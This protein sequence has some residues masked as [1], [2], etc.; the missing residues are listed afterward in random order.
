MLFKRFWCLE[1]QKSSKGG[2]DV[3]SSCGDGC[4]FVGLFV[5]VF[6]FLCVFLFFM[7]V[8]FVYFCFNVDKQDLAR[9]FILCFRF[10]RMVI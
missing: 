8:C 5:I 6:F 2:L 1:R 10:Q 4:W 7:C 3:V 9:P